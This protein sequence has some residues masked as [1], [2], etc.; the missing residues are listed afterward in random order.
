MVGRLLVATG[1]L[2]ALAALLLGFAV[3]PWTGSFVFGDSAFEMLPARLDWGVLFAL[4]MLSFSSLVRAWAE[5]ANPDAAVALTGVRRVARSLA[6]GAVLWLSII[7]MVLIF[8]TLRLSEMARLQDSLFTFSM[9]GLEWSLPAWGILFNPLAAAI[10]LVSAMMHAGLPPFD[11]RSAEEQLAGGR[12]TDIPVAGSVTWTLAD[13]L[14]SLLIAAIAS[15][16]FLGGGDLPY[17][18]QTGLTD[19]IE[20]FFGGGVANLLSLVIHLMIFL[21]KVALVMSLQ[22]GLAQ[23]MG[24]VRFEPVINLCWKGLLPLALLDVVMTGVVVGWTAG[25]GL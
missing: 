13:R 7:P 22:R 11:V 25:V 8:E 10:F 18:S 20:R 21:V 15:V 2:W 3:V 1:P 12:M 5:I 14:R 17:L 9:L 19:F 24:H 6:S 23:I 4:A 16:I